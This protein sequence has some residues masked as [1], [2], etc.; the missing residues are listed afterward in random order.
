M[1]A[2]L[3]R[4][5]DRALAIVSLLPLMEGEAERLEAQLQGGEGWPLYLKEHSL[6]RFI[7]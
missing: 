4:N 5:S 6:Y 1:E 3:G 7:F 2:E